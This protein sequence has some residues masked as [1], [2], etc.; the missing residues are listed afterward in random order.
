M[1]PVA[2]SQLHAK[3]PNGAQP[4]AGV[5]TA[6]QPSA[7]QFSELAKAGVRTVIDL[8]S[9]VEARG[10]DESASVRA[11]GLTYRNIPVTPTTLGNHE[12]DEVRGL[13]RDGARP[14]LIHCGS[15][16]RVGALL[17]PY[18]MLDEKQSRDDALRIAHDV[19]LRSEDLMRAAL[20]YV[21]EQMDDG[22][23]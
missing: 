12:F 6:G 3:L 15:A 18:L 22:S 1:T 10:F 16:N 4:L 9:P 14:M 8:R 19:G 7:A 2:N 21:G 23:I 5:L 13:L 17:I 20:M 11:A